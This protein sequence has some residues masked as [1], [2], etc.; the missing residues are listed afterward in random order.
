MP[1]KKTNPTCPCKKKSCPRHGDCKACRKHHAESKHKMTVYCDKKISLRKFRKG[2]ESA[3][4]DVICTTLSVS[5]SKDYSPEFIEENVKSHSPEVIASRAAESHF[6]VALDGR[7]I[8]GC[9]GITGYWGSDTESY[10]VSIFVLPEYQG[11]GIGRRIIETLEADEYFLRA[12]RTEV[13]SSLTA[14]GFY[15]R[16]GYKYK[17]GITDPDEYEVVRLEKINEDNR[18]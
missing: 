4:S 12:W 2:D 13:G 6:Y 8:I 10:L 17:N 9:G 15:L 14:V 11:R 5:N 3:I 18:L 7:K 1:N 16:M